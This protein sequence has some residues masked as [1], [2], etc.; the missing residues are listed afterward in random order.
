M[1]AREGLEQ[2]EEGIVDE[3]EREALRVHFTQR[4][5]HA[6]RT[7][8]VGSLRRAVP[9]RHVLTVR[10]QT[11]ARRAALWGR[12]RGRRYGRRR[13][14]WCRR[15]RGR[16]RGCGSRRLVGRAGVRMKSSAFS[17]RV[18]ARSHRRHRCVG[19]GSAL[20]RRECA[21]RT[22][23]ASAVRTVA[24]RDKLVRRGRGVAAAV[25]RRRRRCRRGRSRW[26]GCLLHGIG[27]RGGR[28]IVD[29]R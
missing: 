7:L 20:T 25:G 5:R 29:R 4:R 24:L 19:C 8:D 18:S 14:R 21:I 28:R 1:Y 16:R 12:R 2:H 27:R 10:L 3:R 15:R 9:T 6:H 11:R 23:I 26:G 13:G 22:T 17:E